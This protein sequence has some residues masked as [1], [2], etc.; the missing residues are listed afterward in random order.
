MSKK[1]TKR[2]VYVYAYWQEM[3]EPVIMG[4]LHSEL[5]RGNEIFSFEY[6]NNWLK[7]EY[8]QLLDPG[9][10]TIYGSSLFKR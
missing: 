8:A 9:I 10:T 7:S 3:E 1:E 6:D 4:I 2:E 5:L